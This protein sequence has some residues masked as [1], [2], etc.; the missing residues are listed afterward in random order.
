L[1]LT[2]GGKSL[3]AGGTYCK[4]GF[5][6]TVDTDISYYTYVFYD[7]S[8]TSSSI[9]NW[10]W[11]FGDNVFSNK[12]NPEHQFLDEGTYIVK[13]S[14]ECADGSTDTY[15]DTLLIKKII[16]PSCTANFT[17]K[18]DSSQA[19]YT[20]QFT[21]HSVS[22]GDTIISWVWNFGDNSALVYTQ[23]PQHQFAN[24]GFY[25]VTLTVT[26]SQACSATYNDSLFIS[27]LQPTCSADFSFSADS[28]TANP[29]LI[30]FSDQSSSASSIVS[31]H[32]DFSDGDSSNVKNPVHL[33]P[34]Q[35]VFDVKLSIQTTNG[36]SSCTHYPIVVGNPQQYNFWGRVYLGS[37]TTDKCV[38]LLY[39]E[40][41]NGYIV[42][43][44]TV[45]LTSIS[46]TLGVYYF[47]QVFEGKHKVK[48]ILP[49]SSN[50][51]QQFAPTYF[52]DNLFWNY[53]SSINLTSDLSL[54]N[55]NMS[56]V[57]Q[58]T[59]GCQITGSV[60]NNNT[61]ISQKNIQVLLLDNV[62]EVYAY[63]FSDSLGQYS[64]N[65]IPQGNYQVYA[66]ITGLYSIPA[67]VYF[68]SNFDTL[69]NVNVY[70]SKTNS[71]VNID[72]TPEDKAKLDLLLYPNPVDNKLNIRLISNNN[73][74]FEYRIYN[75][76][77]QLVL[78]GLVKSSRYASSIN[79]QHLNS[80]LY[81]LSIYSE[82][83]DLI[84]SKKFIHR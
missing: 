29:K 30:Y 16:P 80:G 13:L 66:E 61:T 51:D 55:V 34:N 56:P 53:T 33:F 54:L 83:E 31:Y 32:W 48:I 40:Y 25:V 3:I 62:Q 43:V 70:L 49:E 67:Q 36:C 68:T 52:G 20:Y 19:I 71:T 10:V 37:L 15:I 1:L 76:L 63:T 14:I 35:G 77:G 18:L 39:K 46:D 17:A 22:P 78:Q 5:T 38:A 12:Q 44:D 65:N 69:N 2:L 82:K 6:Y 59:G 45:R 84:L 9:I 72:E 81:M 11:D 73:S 7:T 26:T 42:P 50:Y 60:F 24:T 58:Q 41:N 57:V 21:D 8:V 28:L 75:N 74:D 4:A 27:T 64:F 79:T 23:H 47:Y